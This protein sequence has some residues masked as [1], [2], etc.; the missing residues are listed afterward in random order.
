VELRVVGIK[1]QTL[2]AL[3]GIEVGGAAAADP[4]GVREVRASTAAVNRGLRWTIPI[5]TIRRRW[6]T[7][8]VGAI[9]RRC[10]L[11]K[12]DHIW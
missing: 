12:T 1:H 6:W 8:P 5:G 7:I 4:R 10:G 9:R 11:S 3:H 2:A